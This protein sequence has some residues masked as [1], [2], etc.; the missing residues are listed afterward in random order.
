M[1]ERKLTTPS[2]MA[3][4][5][6]EEDLSDWEFIEFSGRE[7][8]GHELSGNRSSGQRK[9]IPQRSS[10]FSFLQF[11]HRGSIEPFDAIAGLPSVQCN[12]G[13]AAHAQ[14]CGE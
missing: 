4:L 13:H 8:S 2:R 5:R 11:A 10:S 14:F 9:N 6:W 7:F 1:K 12:P 3:A